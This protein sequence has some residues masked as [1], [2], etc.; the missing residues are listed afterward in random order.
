MFLF[1][2]TRN[3]KNGASASRHKNFVESS[4]F[5]LVAS[6]F[7]LRIENTSRLK[8][9]VSRNFDCFGNRRRNVCDVEF[10]PHSSSSS[11]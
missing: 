10:S 6:V 5:Q 8:K 2:E 7:Y 11:L 3:C 9:V 4:F 1:C